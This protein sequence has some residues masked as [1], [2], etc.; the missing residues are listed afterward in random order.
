MFIPLGT[1]NTAL[2][3]IYY[4]LS[5]ARQGANDKTPAIPLK[6]SDFGRSAL[7]HTQLTWAITYPK[8]SNVAAYIG[9]S[10]PILLVLGKRRTHRMSKDPPLGQ[11]PYFL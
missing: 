8:K 9:P 7:L 1:V 6:T 3:A 4:K 5:T 11:S 10:T 2:T